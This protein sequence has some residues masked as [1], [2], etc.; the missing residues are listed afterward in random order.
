MSDNPGGKGVSL[1]YK[2]VLISGL[3]TLAVVMAVFMGSYFAAKGNLLRNM[4]DQANS[5]AGSL[6]DTLELEITLFRD[7]SQSNLSVALNQLPGDRIMESVNKVKVGEYEL[8]TLFVMGVGSGLKQITASNEL[9]DLWAEQLSSHFSIYQIHRS[10]KGEQAILVSTSFK[11]SSDRTLGKVMDSASPIYQTVVKAEGLYQGFVEI[12]GMPYCVSYK[13]IKDASAVPV[14]IVGTAVSI[15]PVMDYIAKASFTEGSYAFAVNEKGKITVHP[16]IERG[17][18]LSEAMPGFWESFKRVEQNLSKE[19]GQ[20][21]FNYK[22]REGEGYLASLFEIGGLGWRVVLNIP[23]SYILAPVSAMGK[24]MLLYGLP[25]LIA[26]LVLL[27]LVLGKFLAPLKSVLTVATSIAEGDLSLP[28]EG[29]MNSKDEVIAVLGAFERIRLSFK[30]L[31]EKCSELYRKLEARD[32]DLG[33]IE[34]KIEASSN[35]SLE[36]S[37]EIVSVIASVS[38]AVEETNAGVEEVASGAQNTAKITTELSERSNVVNES[39]KAGS[40]SVFETVA[41]INS[42]GESG[43]RIR[44]AISSLDSAIKGITQFVDT[45]T[46]IADQTNL[47]ALNAAIEAARAGEAGKGFAVVADEVR[48]LAEASAEAAK[49]VQE[50]I[51][52]IQERGKEATKEVNETVHLIEEAVASSQETSAQIQS[53]TEQVK[54]ISDGVQSIAAVA[55]EQ[56]AS[57]EEIASA[58]E[59]ILN[60]VAQGQVQAEG[61]EE[62]SRELMEQISVLAQIR[63]EQSALVRDLKEALAFYRLEKSGSAGLVPLD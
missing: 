2:S 62:S 52:D 18:L 59:D 50:V 57:A 23:E 51:S 9:V 35:R 20:I 24:G 13:L 45:I 27:V 34:D 19:S 56:A 38:S 53:I 7:R 5:F 48:K 47:L 1:R 6:K 36:A 30:D 14:I 63:E 12:D 4:N 28:I 40:E 16:K 22:A 32:E 55:E 46:S 41:K 44:N 43:T 11:S 26:G 29:D 61:V 25:A 15:E 54:N 21:N 10:D 3:I 17:A 33:R 39:V 37:R 49:K 42:V 8:P 60:K 31:V 58:M